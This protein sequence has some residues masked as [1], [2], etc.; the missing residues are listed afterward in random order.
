MV[1][2]RSRGRSGCGLHTE[3]RAPRPDGG[4]A[5]STSAPEWPTWLTAPDKLVVA[6]HPCFAGNRLAGLRRYAVAKQIGQ[7]E[8][9]SGGAD[10]GSTEAAGSTGASA[11]GDTAG[12]AGSATG[13]TGSAGSDTSSLTASSDSDVAKLMAACEGNDDAL[14][15]DRMNAQ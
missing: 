2:V 9:P 14:V 13:S 8:A 1:A 11:S 10:S 3:P 5:R 7:L 4:P 6:E 15:I 12:A